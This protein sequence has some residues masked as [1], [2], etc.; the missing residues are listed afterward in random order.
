MI[1]KNIK[2][3]IKDNEKI[4][5]KEIEEELKYLKLLSKDFSTTSKTSTE[6]INLQAIL[7]L[8]KGTEHFI[9]DI[10]GEYESFIHVLKNAS[11]VI[12]MKIEDIFNDKLS[13][14]E[15]KS[16]A[17]LIYY[18][19]EK[20]NIVK[21]KKG[22]KISSQNGLKKWYEKQLYHLIEIARVVSSKYTRS[23]VRKSF[24][25]RFS[26]ILE[27]LLYENPY[28][29]NKQDYYEQIIKTI[30]DINRARDFI[31][32]LS[33]LIQRLAVDKMHILGDIYDRGPGA[34]IIIDALMKYHS[35]D[36][37]WGNHD[38]LW[39]GAASG[40][41]VCAATVLR[42]SMR[43]GNMETLEEGYGINILPLATFALEFYK[44]EEN[45]FFNPKIISGP[46][47]NEQEVGLIRKMHK[48]IS[49][50]Q[51][52]L[53]GQFVKRR[54]EFKMENRLVLENINIKEGTIILN[55]KEY[56]LNDNY[57]P[58]LDTKDPYKLTIEEERVIEKMSQSFQMSS[59]LQN[60][61]N[62]LYVKGGL[63][64]KYNSNLLFHGCI[65]MEADGTLSKFKIAG[66]NYTGKA[67]YD[68][69]EGIAREAFYRKDWDEKKQYNVDI[70]YYL[71]CGPKS[72][73]FGKDRMATFERYFI[74]EKGPQ[75]ELKNPFFTIYRDKIKSCK[76]I[77]RNFKMDTGKSKIIC[78]HV[79]VKV[80][81]GESPIKA[82]GMLLVIDG[83]F[84][85]AYQPQTGTAGYTLIYNSYGMQ[86]ASHESF[87]STKTAID[88]E[89]DILSTKK[90][91]NKLTDRIRI[92]DTDIGVDIKHQIK[93]LKMLLVAFNMGFIKENLFRYDRRGI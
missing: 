50:I 69:F 22:K 31:I 33:N 46:D 28:R 30:I 70:M 48:A 92:K 90:V 45:D 4:G 57:F 74:E 17:T 91:L 27:E 23:K 88:E 9:S 79:P 14:A 24:P 7:N 16:L 15:K 55:N 13:E 19:V 35:V 6:I 36:F 26:Y 53:E 72:P 43:Y 58:T 89:R 18:P 67:L 51:F 71:W 64:L 81:K 77:L 1:K 82:N 42:V 8:P 60:H 66:K 10:H 56:K 5:R 20:M 78:G 2:K 75:K 29:L 21:M 63:Y 47:L 32:A 73:L 44:D 62:F 52:K 93:E 80:N 65:P 40:S 49:I 3:N 59:R 34:D 54:P 38:I 25:G 68:K 76:L 86:L 12:K 85:K 61:I 39:M 83:G 11:G 87:D 37:Q 84:S 41:R